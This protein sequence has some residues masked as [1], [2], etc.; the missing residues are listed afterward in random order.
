MPFDGNPNQFETKKPDAFSLEG[1]IAWLETQD[2]NKGYC[3]SLP[4]SCLYHHFGVAMG[5]DAEHA[6]NKTI[7]RFSENLGTPPLTEPFTGLAITTP[8]TYGAAL[9]RAL[10]LRQKRQP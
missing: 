6:Y 7:K 2:P 1:L 4:G 10:A 5:F 3:W 9:E 8:H